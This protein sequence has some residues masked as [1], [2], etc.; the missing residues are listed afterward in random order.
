MSFEAK[1]ASLEAR[2]AA[3]ERAKAAAEARATAAEARAILAE[4]RLIKAEAKAE[5]SGAHTRELA[6]TKLQ[7]SYFMLQ[8]AQ[9]RL[10]FGPMPGSG[11][12]S[13]AS[14]Q[15]PHSTGCEC[16]TP[17]SGAFGAGA[18]SA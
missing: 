13:S 16:H 15:R 8:S 7:A 5:V 2:L 4:T 3:A 10:A 1:V 6:Q 11:S 17:V 18:L 9:G 12:S 14:A